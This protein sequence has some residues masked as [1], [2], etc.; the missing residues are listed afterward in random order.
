MTPRAIAKLWSFFGLVLLAATTLFFFRYRGMGPKDDP[1]G[2]LGYKPT[3]IAALALPVELLLL[4]IF[5]PISLIWSRHVGG[6][7]WAHRQPV[8]YFE[9]NE[10]NP[11]E[12]LGRW[13]QGICI[14][15]ALL[16]P[17]VLT[18]LMMDGYLKGGV[19]IDCECC[20]SE[21]KKICQLPICQ[22]R[23]ESLIK[24]RLEHFDYFRLLDIKNQTGKRYS[25]GEPDGPEY[26]AAASWIYSSLLAISVL[27]WLFAVWSVFSLD[28]R[29]QTA[30]AMLTL[31]RTQRRATI[32]IRKALRNLVQYIRKLCIM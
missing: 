30:R 16:V 20:K 9:D 13:Y 23:N 24:S 14:F 19:Y 11:S 6:A 3:T 29:H 32:F 2:I 7:T 27:I 8:F 1:F 31:T 17:F 12:K 26:F 10:I 22:N 5:L 25:F 4:T 21:N 15:F 18:V 28:I